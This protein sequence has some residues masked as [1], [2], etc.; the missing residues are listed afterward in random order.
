MNHHSFTRWISASESADVI[1]KGPR[2]DDPVHGPQ[3]GRVEPWTGGSHASVVL[4]GSA[5]SP[6][7]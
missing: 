5:S 7:N 4:M 3:E 2:S 6:G 1:R